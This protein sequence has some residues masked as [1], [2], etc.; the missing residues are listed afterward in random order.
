MT[1]KKGNRYK[2]SLSDSDNK[3]SFTH[4]YVT[5]FPISINDLEQMYLILTDCRI[6]E[7]SQGLKGNIYPPVTYD[8]VNISFKVSYIF[9]GLP[10]TTE[11]LYFKYV[12]KSMAKEELFLIEMKKIF[13]ATAEI[14]GFRL[15][16][17]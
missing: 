12:K 16:Y 14:F 11:K 17:K 10:Y 2:V 15:T 6:N 1:E 4:S 8:T 7:I 3:D 9:N 13:G 5:P